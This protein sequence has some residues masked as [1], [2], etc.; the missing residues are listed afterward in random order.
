MDLV[1]GGALSL[2]ERNPPAPW[3]S[4]FP[5]PGFSLL[6]ETV[7]NRDEQHRLW[8]QTTHLL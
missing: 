6:S 7:W 5:S 2:E 8:S 4:D 3:L 1:E